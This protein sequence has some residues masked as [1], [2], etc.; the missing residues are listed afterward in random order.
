MGPVRRQ[1]PQI[2]LRGRAGFSRRCRADRGRRAPSAAPSSS[3]AGA[4]RPPRS[5]PTVPCPSSS[6]SRRTTV[7]ASSLQLGGPGGRVGADHAACRRRTTPACSAPR[8]PRRPAPASGRRRRAP[9]GRAPSRGRRPAGRAW[10]RAAAG[11][12]RRGATPETRPRDRPVA[13]LAACGAPSASSRAVARVSA[14]ARSRPSSRCSGSGSAPAARVA[15]SRPA[16]AAVAASSRSSGL[17]DHLAVADQVA[18]PGQGGRHVGGDRRGDQHLLGAGDEV[19][20]LRAA[21]GVELGEDVVE[22][23]DRVVAVRAQQVVRRQAQRQRER[24]GLP[25]RGVPLDRQPPGPGVPAR[26]V[27]S[28]S[29]SSSR[30][31]PTR[32]TPRSISSWRRRSTSSSSASAERGPVGGVRRAAR[33]TAC[34]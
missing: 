20:E 2:V 9:A 21:L 31:G 14:R 5:A 22:D 6:L 1:G 8:P 10:C 33:T 4:G 32:E 23:Q 34:R 18:H 24:P 17:T 25:V 13:A 3:S 19:G 12:A 30:C 7:G 28:V 27:P 15:G 16:P 26:P 11:R 29:S